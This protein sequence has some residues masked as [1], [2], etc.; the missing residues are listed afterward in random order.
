M[1]RVALGLVFYLLV[2]PM[3]GCSYLYYN[4]WETLGVEKRE[5]LKRDISQAQKAQKDSQDA[6]VSTLDKIQQL[7]GLEGGKLESA[8]R[9]LSK[10]YEAADSAAKTLRNRTASI[11][12]IAQDLFAEWRAEA[13]SMHHSQMRRQSIARLQETEKRFK[14]M[15][16][17]MQSAET[18]MEPV[19]MTMRDHVLYLK[20]NL[21]AM[22]LSSFKQEFASI[23]TD[24]HQLIQ[25]MNRS[26]Q[27]SDRF[28][29][30]LTS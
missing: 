20:H 23:Q 18:S 27:Q 9:G 26:I 29:Q 13:E 12:S 7:Y 2:S 24:I 22:A 11:E 6:F 8:Y 19:L 14:E 17:A 10:D 21:N 3:M 30:T 4:F 28:L 15:L 1:Y 25:N 5:L 16:V